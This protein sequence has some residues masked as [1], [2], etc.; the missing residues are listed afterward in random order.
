MHYFDYAFT[1]TAL[2]YKV[3]HAILINGRT[4]T[5]PHIYV[6]IGKNTFPMIWEQSLMITLPEPTVSLKTT[7]VLRLRTYLNVTSQVSE[8]SQFLLSTCEDEMLFW[9]YPLC[10][11]LKSMAS[12]D[13]VL[14]DI[15]LIFYP[16]CLYD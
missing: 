15:N 5:S 8:D 16:F 9:H 13:L 11:G 12:R 3:V 10:S 6:I 14:Y 2:H 4:L 7:N 1:V